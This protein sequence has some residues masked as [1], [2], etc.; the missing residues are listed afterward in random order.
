MENTASALSP[1]SV[2]FICEQAYSEKLFEYFSKDND[3]LLPVSHARDI[4]VLSYSTEGEVTHGNTLRGGNPLQF[5]WPV[6][7]RQ[8]LTQLFVSRGGLVNSGPTSHF[9][10][11]SKKPDRRFL[12]ASSALSEGAEIFFAGLCLLPH[13][14]KEVRT[15]HLDTSSIASVVMASLLMSRRE[16]LPKIRTFHSY[17]KLK[18]HNFSKDETE[19]VLISASQSGQMAAQLAELVGRRSQIVTIFSSSPSLATGETLCDLKFDGIMNPAGI[20]A[21]KIN[22][23]FEGSRPINLVGEHF[24]SEPEAPRAAL[25]GVLQNPSINRSFISRLAGRQVF[26]CNFKKNR[27]MPSKSVWIDAGQF[28]KTENYKEWLELICLREIPA[29]VA[30]IVY[31]DGSDG[32][33]AFAK[34]IV[35][36]IKRHGVASN[37]RL[38]SL[39]EIDGSQGSLPTSPP[40]KAPIVIAGGITGHGDDLL[41]VSRALRDWAPSSHRVF[42]TPICVPSSLAALK[43]LDQNLCQPRSHVFK[44][45]DAIVIDR[46]KLSGSWERERQFLSDRY[47]ELPSDLRD[48][49]NVLNSS[50]GMINNL[51]LSGKKS[52]LSL[53]KNFAFWPSDVDCQAALQADVFVAISC[54]IQNM[55]TNADVASDRRI[56]NNS[57]THTVI[58][59]GAF[60]RF[61]DGVIQASILRAAEP[62]E[63]NYTDAPDESRVMGGVIVDM[64]K[65][66]DRQQG[67]AV[68]EFLMAILTGWIQLREQD[69]ALVRAEL[70][71]NVN[72]NEAQ[73]WLAR[74]IPS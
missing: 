65:L 68:T 11:P 8:G 46:Q 16:D 39:T 72:L 4:V 29:A 26:S 25:P 62:V 40:D 20:P 54:L 55:R 32:S 59:A 30:A 47:D 5:E 58:A 60:A 17:E 24:L 67:E 64:I 15:I 51:F 10:K 27:Y 33:E 57:N 43:V 41:S 28:L 19:V 22:D 71:K 56:V 38:I 2:Y 48:R 53:R 13:L 49:L 34:D 12:R 6:V 52:Q 42:L 31:I 44:Y 21:R 9:V 73:S 63:L 36:E 18:Q 50:K 35:D 74:C 7:S 14:K 1:E 61:N 70:D 23:N 69:M 37:C 66:V 3:V 45:M